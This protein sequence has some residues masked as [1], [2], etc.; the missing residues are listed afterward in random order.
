MVHRLCYP[1]EFRQAAINKGQQQLIEKGKRIKDGF[2]G[3]AQL[4]E[5]LE[6]DDGIPC[7]CDEE[8]ELKQFVKEFTVK[9]NKIVKGDFFFNQRS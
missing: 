4:I 1:R 5:L 3:M 2:D 8:Q 9:A 6:S 7:L